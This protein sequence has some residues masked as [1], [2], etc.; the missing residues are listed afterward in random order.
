MCY[1]CVC[2]YIYIERER[3]RERERDVYAYGPNWVTFSRKAD[4]LPGGFLEPIAPLGCGQMGSTLMG[5]L[6]K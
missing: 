5:P 4:L 2:I 1:V 3:W 6:K